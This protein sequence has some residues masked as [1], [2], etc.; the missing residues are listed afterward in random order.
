[1]KVFVPFDEQTL[2]LAKESDA[3]RL[4]PFQRE[5]ACFRAFRIVE[6][7]SEAVAHCYPVTQEAQVY[8]FVSA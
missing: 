1:M 4:V 8:D 6:E 5:Y 3:P 7:P 2:E